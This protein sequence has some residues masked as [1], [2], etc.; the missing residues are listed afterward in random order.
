MKEEKHSGTFARLGG[1]TET[2]LRRQLSLP[3]LVLYGVGIT[4]GAGIY[5][6]IG[7]VAG[8][9][10]VF[11][12]W[13]FLLAAVV[14][15]FT[16]ASYA[17][18]STRYPVSS[19]E[20]AYVDAAFRS[21]Q[22][23]TVVGLLTA[24]IGTISSAAVASGAAGY[25]RQFLDLP[26]ELVVLA[27]LLVLGAVAAR[28]ILESV[29]LASL[30]TLIEV[31]G[32]LAII[33][34]ALYADAPFVAALTKVPPFEYAALSGI[35]F[36]SL[37]AFFAFIGFEDLANIA[38]EAREPHRNLPRAMLITLAVSTALY[39]TIAAVAVSAVS[40]ERL[41]ASPAPLSLVFQQLASVSPATIT[42]IAIAA[43]LNTTLAQ[44]T[45][46]ARVLYGM[47]R[48]G[49]L[50]RMF[51]RVSAGTRT[52]LIATA[53]VTAVAV[54]LALAFPL[55]RLA[56]STSIATLIVF[57]LVNVALL[58]IR[59]RRE[60]SPNPHIRVPVW[61]PLVGFLTC[62]ALAGSALLK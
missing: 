59:Y 32:L 21:R 1:D 6:L 52:P 18:L 34:T 46:A 4:I 20:A 60:T 30:F 22:L 13:S 42:I 49:N 16:V 29:L 5:V 17:E 51:G 9:A 47:A 53:T 7:E 11:A 15:I 58:L 19:G 25:I 41:A 23:T 57:A 8:S 3:L 54:A 62:L 45:M 27:V 33:V 37:L 38:E 40:V 61:M 31:G 55:V 36:G 28:G 56:E 43:T 48:Q 14:M 24:A 12:P 2:T 10:A 26:H 39:V 35:A 50:P 44:M